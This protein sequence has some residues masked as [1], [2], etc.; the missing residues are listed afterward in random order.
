M[1]RIRRKDLKRDRFVEEV[2]HQVEYVSGHRK[3][4]IA[5]GVALVVLL[6]G[7][8]GYWSYA[9]QRSINSNAAL[10]EAINLFHGVVS[11]EARPGL[12]TFATEIE[13]ID[14]VTR[15]LDA[16]LL[17]YS[18]TA[19]AAGASFYS[20]LLDREE[21]NLA[22]AEAHFEQAVRGSGSEYPT[23]A[24]LALGT[25]LFER[26]DAEAAR[27]HFRAVVEN[28][29]RTVSKDRATIEYARTFI[30]SDPQQAR[31]LLNEIQ[32]QNGPASTMASALLETFDEG[33]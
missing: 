5:G 25:L 13:R 19:A 1:A 33:G 24:R 14:T 29:S 16:I 26:G 27:E 4:F 31:D 10:Q 15:A 28:P 22:E 2:T 6:V 3:Q 17:D 32:A 12:K 11:V 20:G 30:E 8:T 7:G 23:L 21:E 18:G 9:R